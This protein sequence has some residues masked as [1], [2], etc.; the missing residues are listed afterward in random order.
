MCDMYKI[1]KN[2]IFAF[3]LGGILFSG[4]TYAATLLA[5]NITYDNTNSG[6][7]STNVQGA[8]DELYTK[9]NS[10]SYEEY[11]G[12]T[13]YTPSGSVQT[14]PTY[15]KVLKSN[16]T[17]DAVPSNFVELSSAAN[18][19]SNTILSGY[20]GYN[21][22]GELVT[23]TLSTNC[24]GG[25]YNH[26]ANTQWSI[27]VG[28]APDYFSASYESNGVLY[29]MYYDLVKNVSTVVNVTNNS[30]QHNWGGRLSLENNTFKTNFATTS[31]HYVYSY[32]VNYMACK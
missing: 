3:I 5:T 10:N 13:S 29:L 32:N 1:N 12:S 25:V 11:T 21:G 9:A 31:N 15:N 7:T 23:G 26:A 20:K 24:V 18:V 2:I 6:I 4:V 8:I 22:T 19:T 30:I 28:F 16:I 27:N 17:I 14:I